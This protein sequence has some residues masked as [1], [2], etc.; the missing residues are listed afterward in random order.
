MCGPC[1]RCR[2]VIDTFFLLNRK[3]Y[4]K[5]A[6]YAGGPVLPLEWAKAV[7][8][9]LGEVCKYA[10]GP[11]TPQGWASAMHIFLEGW[12][13]ANMREAHNPADMG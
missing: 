13:R 11:V 8:T 4:A 2:S 12:K 10:G 5:Y 3:K 7:H 6:K 9:F 1:Q